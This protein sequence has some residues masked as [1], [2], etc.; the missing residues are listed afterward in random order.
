M[1]LPS[2]I[3]LYRTT[4]KLAPTDAVG[5]IEVNGADFADKR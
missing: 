3:Y 5:R 2:T 1:Q 4:H